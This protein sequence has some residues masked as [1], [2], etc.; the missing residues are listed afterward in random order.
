MLQDI[1]HRHDDRLCTTLIRLCSTHGEVGQ[2]LA[3]YEWMRD[4]PQLGG[5]GLTPTV[6]TFTAAMRAALTGGLCG[7]AFKVCP[8][9]CSS[10]RAAVR[11]SCTGLGLNDQPS[12]TMPAE[13]ALRAQIWE[14]ARAAGCQPDCRMCTVHIEVCTRAGQPDRALEM[15]HYMQ[16]AAGD[17]L[18]PSVHTYTAALRAAA[19]D[20]ASCPQAMAIW[21]DMLR[22]GCQPSGGSSP[23]RLELCSG[24]AGCPAVPL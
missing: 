11:G 1:G 12:C 17:R 6:F 19:A 7:V 2:A 13:T 10:L 16:Q 14:D 21:S 23:W 22:A 24:Q 20:E 5:Q 18:R 9:R 15:Y 3:L 4:P 8:W